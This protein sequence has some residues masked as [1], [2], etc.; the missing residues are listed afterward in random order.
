MVRFLRAISQTSWGPAFGQ[1]LASLGVDGDI[2]TMQAGTPAAGKVR[3]KTGSR[4]AATPN[5]LQGI[6]TAVA[7]VGY[8]DTV[9]GRQLAFAILLRDLPFSSFDDFMVARRDQGAIAAALQ[10]IF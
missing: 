3:A 5:G 4:A 7:M 9:S 2:A 6:V 8:V 1:G 10:Q